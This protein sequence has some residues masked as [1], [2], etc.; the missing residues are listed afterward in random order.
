MCFFAGKCSSCNLAAPPSVNKGRRITSVVVR[1]ISQISRSGDHISP[2]K[3]FYGKHKNYLHVSTPNPHT[4]RATLALKSGPN[5][6][7]PHGEVGGEQRRVR[8]A[9]LLGSNLLLPVCG[10]P[11]G[12]GRISGEKRPNETPRWFGPRAER[13]W[14]MDGVQSIDYIDGIT[15]EMLVEGGGGDLLD[16]ADT[17]LYEEPLQYAEDVGGS[18]SSD[19]EED[20]EEVFAADET[21]E[22]DEEGCWDAVDEEDCAVG[23]KSGKVPLDLPP[24]LKRYLEIDHFQVLKPPK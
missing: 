12:E 18:V 23:D 11:L 5:G 7:S 20:E 3:H 19:E 8:L 10:R 2:Q 9:A 24:E 6:E 14:R 15:L 13:G 17:V 21:E 1:R 16:E 4:G 22:D